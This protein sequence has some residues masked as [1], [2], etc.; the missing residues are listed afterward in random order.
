MNKFKISLKGY[1]IKNIKT[2][3]KYDKIG[4]HF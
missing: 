1:K 2:I 3:M 4:V